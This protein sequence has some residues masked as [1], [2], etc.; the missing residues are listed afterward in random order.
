MKFGTPDLTLAR[1]VRIWLDNIFDTDPGLTISGD[2][3]P[4]IVL[5]GFDIVGSRW[6]AADLTPPQVAAGTAVTLNSVNTVDN[7][8]S[9]RRRLIRA[10]RATAIRRSSA[11]SN[12]SNSSSRTCSR[13]TRSRPSSRFRST[14]ITAATGG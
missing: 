12:P 1:H 9:T 10:R 14:R 8:A 5:G 4:F 3:R 13:P 11:A 7:A 6:L 2:E